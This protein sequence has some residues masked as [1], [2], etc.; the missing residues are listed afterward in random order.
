MDFTD[1]HVVV[2]GGTGALG[3]ALI[4]R[5]LVLGAVVHVPAF[6]QPVDPAW[7]H[8]GRVQLTE[9][10][11]G[12][13]E[14]AVLAFYAELPELWASLH[15]AG[16]FAMSDLG[17]T[18][19]AQQRRMMA[20]NFDTCFL[21][22]RGAA[23]AMDDGGRIVNVAARP[24]LEPRSGAGM[25]PYTASKAAVAAL[26]S[27]LAA[28]L[29]DRRI[30]VNAVAPSIIDTPANRA[31]MPGADHASWVPPQDLADTILWLASPA[32]AGSGGVLPV[33]GRA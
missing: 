11:D 16:G 6:E 25:A 33:Y 31:A 2:T 22:C 5:L 19:L 21:S 4:H 13:D 17:D 27:A 23:G 3:T 20:M 10:V 15:C 18:A 32:N 26:T 29:A 24:A 28:E 12:T 1:R 8:H 30:L 7:P 14:D 9:G